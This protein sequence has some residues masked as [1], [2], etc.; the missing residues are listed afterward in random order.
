MW[1]LQHTIEIVS[2][3]DFICVSVSFRT[4]QGKRILS[5]TKDTHVSIAICTETT[6]TVEETASESITII[7]IGAKVKIIHL[8]T[9]KHR[10]PYMPLSC[11]RVM[12]QMWHVLQINCH[13]CAHICQINIQDHM[14]QHQNSHWKP[15]NSV[16]S[17]DSPHQT[18]SLILCWTCQQW[19][20]H[21]TINVTQLTHPPAFPSTDQT[22]ILKI[23]FSPPTPTRS[24]DL[25]ELECLL[26]EDFPSENDSPTKTTPLSPPY[27][28]DEDIIPATPVKLNPIFHLKTISYQ[29][30]ISI[31]CFKCKYLFYFCIH[32]TLCVCI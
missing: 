27:P 18:R 21:F 19:P 10:L 7:I 25:E 29:E 32:E 2:W 20:L 6:C 9:I 4:F 26:K 28:L 30:P 1:G 23:T 31:V 13:F 15:S 16:S 5:T 24:S 3:Y 22:A 17:A 14:Q 11:N 12:S 8:W